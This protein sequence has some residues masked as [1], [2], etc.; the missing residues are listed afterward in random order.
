MNQR[1]LRSGLLLS[2][3]LAAATAHAQI[4]G[5]RAMQ[6]L[7]LSTNA[8]QAALG[9][10]NVSAP[11]ALDPQ[12][13]LANPALIDTA[14]AGKL[15]F[16]YV[17]FVS[18]IA[19]NSLQYGFKAGKLGTLSAGLTYLNYGSFNSF[20]EAGI[21]TGTFN[22]QDYAFSLTA[23][24]QQGPFTLGV[25]ARLAAST[26]AANKS[27]AVAADF[28]AR[29][30][31]PT[32]QFSV[33]L[34]VKNVGVQ[35]KPFDGADREPL[36]FD[37]QLGVSY[38]PEHMPVRFS[39]TAHRLYQLDI[40]YLDPAAKGKLDEN[41]NEIKPKKTL[42]D[43]I[44]RHFIGSAEIL[45]SKNVNVR[46]GYNYLRRREM[47]LENVSGGAGFSFG[48]MIKIGAIQLEFT[49]AMYG[50]AGGGTYLTLVSD[51]NRIFKKK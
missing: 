38:K 45:L 24:R 11:A 41:N 17:N 26:Y 27:S 13:V 46:I 19:Q 15:A 43:Q 21:S 34:V 40:V 39:L 35:L 16:S 12:A 18:D 50:P 51:L 22:A 23:A 47:R 37:V 3:A 25:T 7:D 6:F 9:G 20:D 4:G 44:G 48:A 32:K 36:P 14:M 1:F 28:G 10:A 42:A 8:R 49:R 33:G 5:Q 30:Q 2:F 29:F 31:H